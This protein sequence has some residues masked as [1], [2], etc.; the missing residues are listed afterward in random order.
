T[1]LEKPSAFVQRWNQKS[2][3]AGLRYTVQTSDV[4]DPD[5][6]PL[7]EGELEKLLLDAGFTIHRQNRIIELFP[8]NEPPS[9]LDRLVIRFVQRQY[10]SNG[11][12]HAVLTG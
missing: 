7:Q 11:F 12:I 6:Y 1:T 5:E 9:W 8:R 3:A 2:V 10:R 4:Q